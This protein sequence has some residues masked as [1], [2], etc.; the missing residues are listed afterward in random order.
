MVVGNFFQLIAGE[1]ENNFM[2]TDRCEDWWKRRICLS[3]IEARG[4]EKNSLALC[5]TDGP[6]RVVPPAD[7][8][9][10][11]SIRRSQHVRFQSLGCVAS[12]IEYLPQS[13]ASSSLRLWIGMY[14]AKLVWWC[15]RIR[16]I[17]QMRLFSSYF[18]IRKRHSHM[19]DADKAKKIDLPNNTFVHSTIALTRFT[20]EGS[21]EFIEVRCR[22]HHPG[23]RNNCRIFERYVDS[24]HLP[25]RSQWMNIGENTVQSISI[26]HFRA[27]RVCIV[28]KEHLFGRILRQTGKTFLRNIIRLSPRFVGLNMTMLMKR[29]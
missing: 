22:T 25:K 19:I 17:H 9:N 2:K 18:T 7:R 10:A 23:K 21:I 26:G 3:G 14:T 29:R 27:P 6:L 1:N 15:R 8:V 11:K 28:D 5:H 13:S 20:A 12:W 24:C 16:I 4:W